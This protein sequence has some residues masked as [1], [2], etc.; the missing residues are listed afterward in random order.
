MTKFGDLTWHIIVGLF[1]I[2]ITFMLVRP[3]APAARAVTDVS[4]ALASLVKQATQ[5]NG[6]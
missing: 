3:G 2:A 1:I 4:N 5:Y 6:Q